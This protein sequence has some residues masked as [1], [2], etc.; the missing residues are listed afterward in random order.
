MKPTA[1]AQVWLTLNPILYYSTLFTKIKWLLSSLGWQIILTFFLFDLR[2]FCQN[3]VLKSLACCGASH[4]CSLGWDA[5]LYL[6]ES[7]DDLS[8][9]PK[10]M[11]PIAKPSISR[12]RWHWLAIQAHWAYTTPWTTCPGQAAS[13]GSTAACFLCGREEARAEKHIGKVVAIVVFYSR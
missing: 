13:S 7:N 11:G 12:S 10:W 4:N 5:G 9:S 8:Y 2:H 3:E 6:K 1:K